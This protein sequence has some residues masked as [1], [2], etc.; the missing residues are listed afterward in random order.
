MSPSVGAA[1][2]SGCLQL[3]FE[4]WSFTSSSMSTSVR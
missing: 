3:Q 4:E 2:K 1:D